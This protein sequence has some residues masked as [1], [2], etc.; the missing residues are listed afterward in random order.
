MSTCFHNFLMIV[1]THLY[2]YGDVTFFS[3]SQALLALILIL[4][5][6]LCCLQL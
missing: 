2:V 4:Q 3:W 5:F 6:T 1:I